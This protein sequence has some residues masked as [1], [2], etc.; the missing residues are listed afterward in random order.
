[1]LSLFFLLV[2]LFPPLYDE[3]KMTYIEIEKINKNL[4]KNW[5]T[6]TWP[7]NTS[8]FSPPCQIWVCSVL[9]LLKW[10]AA[11]PLPANPRV[12]PSRCRHLVGLGR[13]GLP[14]TPWLLPLEP[15]QHFLS[16]LTG[17]NSTLTVWRS[18]LILVC[19]WGVYFRYITTPVPGHIT[20]LD[21]K[22]QQSKQK[23]AFCVQQ[24]NAQFPIAVRALSSA[25][26][27]IHLHYSSSLFFLFSFLSY[28]L[29]QVLCIH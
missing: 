17:V 11:P 24:V 14:A 1:M 6:L 13:A 3:H 9:Q 21:F 18:W 4:N 20:V 16:V 28:T 22:D 27:F 25:S 7:I 12:I 26:S 29:Q 10:K 23:M 19:P 5:V 2:R 15:W 8:I